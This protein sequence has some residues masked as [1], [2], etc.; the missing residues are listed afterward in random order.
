MVAHP[1]LPRAARCGLHKGWRRSTR[2]VSHVAAAQR[3]HARPLPVQVQYHALTQAPQLETCIAYAG[4]KPAY[5]QQ[6]RL[7]RLEAAHSNMPGI[8]CPALWLLSF[9]GISAQTTVVSFLPSCQWFI[10]HVHACKA[11]FTAAAA[12]PWPGAAVLT[13]AAAAASTPSPASSAAAACNG[14]VNLPLVIAW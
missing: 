4:T 14:H 11:A 9:G 6:R 8:L 7:M 1:A 12:A 13:A 5:Q 3:P 2:H 10:R